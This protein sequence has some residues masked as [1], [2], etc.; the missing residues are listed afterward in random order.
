MYPSDVAGEVRIS[1][2]VR[3]KVKIKVVARFSQAIIVTTILNQIFSKFDTF[4]KYY[5]L[6]K[7]HI[8]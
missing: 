2:R 1:V 5:T 7:L 8:I 4:N 6:N 3:M